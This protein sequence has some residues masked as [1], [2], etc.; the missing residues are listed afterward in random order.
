LKRFDSLFDTR[1]LSQNGFY[2]AS[3]QLSLYYH[4]VNEQAEP[5]RIWKRYIDYFPED[6]RGYANLINNLSQI[7]GNQDSAIFR[8]YKQWNGVHPDNTAMI[9]PYMKF[10]LNAGNRAFTATDFQ[11][12]ERYYLA[13]NEL[14][15]THAPA[16]NN[17]G[18]VYAR[19]HKFDAAASMFQK[20][21]ALDSSYVDPWY[22]LAIL[23]FDSG[24]R[25]EGIK[26]LKLAAQRGS[27]KAINELHVRGISKF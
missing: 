12:A 25:D 16:Y 7:P 19:E 10:C 3:L 6:D 4:Q 26:L 15:S 1:T 11:D 8:T 21:I 9:N 17:L 13:L 18:N 24:K 14:D 27:A 22:N 2:G 23:Y 20:A 5:V